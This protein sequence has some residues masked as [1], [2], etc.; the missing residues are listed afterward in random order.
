MNAVFRSKVDGSFIGLALVLPCIGLAVLFAA[1]PGMRML[2]LPLVLVLLGTA[3][4]WWTLLATSY[5][6][7]SEQ[8]VV[9]CGLFSWRIP[10]ATITAIRESRSPRSGPAL[11]LERLEVLYGAGKVLIIS[12]RDKARFIATL[13]KRCN[14]ARLEG[15]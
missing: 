7:L 11:S 14:L 4:V 1:P 9:R 15:E 10:F 3:M 5:E 12:P 2:W 6:L 13:S 8:L